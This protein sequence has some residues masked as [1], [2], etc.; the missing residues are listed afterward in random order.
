MQASAT[1]TQDENRTTSLSSPDIGARLLSG[2]AHPPTPRGQS[3]LVPESL[4]TLAH[5][6]VSAVCTAPNPAGVPGGELPPSSV[7]RGIVALSGSA[8]ATALFRV[9]T[10]S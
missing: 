7:S 8:A 5:F 9:S 3:T 4:T 2:L 6:A 10:I 1:I